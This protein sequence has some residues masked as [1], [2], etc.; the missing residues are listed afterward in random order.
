M[1]SSRDF[2]VRGGRERTVVGG[3][4]VRDPSFLPRKLSPNPKQPRRPVHSRPRSLVVFD[5]AGV[6]GSWSCLGAG[7]S[8]IWAAVEA[9]GSL[10]VRAQAKAT[11]L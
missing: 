10:G 9:L 6:T 3:A 4:P 5:A 7:P 1:K 11:M 2:L 8:P